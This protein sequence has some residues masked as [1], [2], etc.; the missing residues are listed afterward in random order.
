MRAGAIP[1]IAWG[2]LLAILFSVHLLMTGAATGDLVDTLCYG[3]ALA[4]VVAC[5]VISVVHRHETA[6]RG[7]PEL[8][9]EAVA[10]PAASLGAPLLALAFVACGFGLV[11]GSFL[12]FGAGGVFVGA[13]FAL[14]R[15]LRDE[16]R[17]RR[18]WSADGRVR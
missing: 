8:D 15:E 12:V 3:G 4:L 11:F 14:T 10:V 6:R 17:A 16:R 5:A 1:L 9:T 18:G 7:S 2:V 13:V